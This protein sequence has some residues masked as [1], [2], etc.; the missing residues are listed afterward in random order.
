MRIL[1]IEDDETVAGV[2]TAGMT[3]ARH[4]VIHALDG[5]NG[6]ARALNGRFDVMI[7]DRQ[8]PGGVDGAT[9]L[10]QLREQR[11][12]TPV[13]FLSAL[14]DLSDWMAGLDSGGDD[15]IV[16]PFV[17]SELLSRVEALHQRQAA[18]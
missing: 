3:E 7:F 12:T 16:K 6:L 17:F 18:E 9:L 4:E 14:G 15:Y 13:L 5:E 10:R 8:L 11:V 2:V 1:L